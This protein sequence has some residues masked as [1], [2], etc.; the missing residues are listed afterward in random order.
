MVRSR[1][2][3]TSALCAA[4]FLAGCGGGSSGGGSSSGPIA[5]APSPTPTPTAQ[6]TLRDRQLWAEAQIRQW[7]LF[8]EDL[9]ASLSPDGFATVQAYIDALT[10]TA[11]AANKDRFF[12]YITSI[13]EENAFFSS[14]QTAAFGIRLEYDSTARRTY[15]LDVFETGPAFAAGVTVLAVLLTVEL[16]AAQAAVA[17]GA[18]IY[19]ARNANLMWSVI[20]L[21]VQAG[22]SLLL[23]P[24][25]GPLGGGV[26]AALALAIAALLQSVAKSRLLQAR[27]GHA[28][29]GWRPSLL[30]AGIPAFGVGLLVLRTPEPIQLSIGFFAILG[31]YGLI[32]WRF[33]FKGADRLLFARGLKKI[34]DEAASLPLAPILPPDAR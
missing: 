21:A 2:A 6:C 10:A 16:F 7:Y 20:G 9:P 31:S 30:L 24:M 19:V 17:E 12:T 18:L 5:V 25:A 11:R 15:I 23:V 33:G 3:L 27:L 29:S 4:L 8:P 28:V 34:E 22:L 26:G 32:I 14:G 13:A 1:S